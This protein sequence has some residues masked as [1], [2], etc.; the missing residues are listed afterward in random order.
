MHQATLMGQ[1]AADD[2]AC[3]RRHPQAP[4]AVGTRFYPEVEAEL[5]GSTTPVLRLES[6]DPSVLA[7]E[8]GALVA[9]A[10]GASAVLIS[11]PDGAVVDFLHVWVA[12]VTS[13]AL[14]R[15]DGDR[16]RGPIHLAVG[17]DAT[18]VPTIWDGTQQLAGDGDARWTASDG[19]AAIELLRDGSADRRRIRAR[20][21]GKATVTVAVGDAT[22]ALDVEVVP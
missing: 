11:S 21:P 15:R 20:A 19:G 18:L 5:A 14:A 2:A 3:S 4:L 16:V 12:P 6:A 7:V 8:D 22:T 17:E 10:P 13:V 9:K 1:C